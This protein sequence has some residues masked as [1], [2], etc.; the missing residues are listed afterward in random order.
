MPFP[1]VNHPIGRVVAAVALSNTIHLPSKSRSTE[2]D[3]IT[4]ELLLAQLCS[5]SISIELHVT[6]HLLSFIVI[7]RGGR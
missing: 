2:L 1:F 3:G 5:T 6:I 7:A 4:G